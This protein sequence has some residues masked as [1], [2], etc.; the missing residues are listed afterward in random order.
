L[1]DS[2]IFNK[3]EL[4]LLYSKKPEFRPIK[5]LTLNDAKKIR[6]PS[7]NEADVLTQPSIDQIIVEFLKQ[8]EVNIKPQNVGDWNGWDTIA[9]IDAFMNRG[10]GG[11]TIANTLFY[12]SRSNQVSQSAQDWQTWKRWALDHKNFDKYK[13]EVIQNIISHN[14]NAIKE[15]EALIRKAELHNKNAIKEVEESIRKAELHNEKLVKKLQKLELKEYVSQLVESDN[16]RKKQIRKIISIFVLLIVLIGS[17]RFIRSVKT[18]KYIEFGLENGKKENYKEAISDFKN[19]INLNSNSSTAYTAYYNLGIIYNNLE[20]FE[21]ALLNLNKGLDL[22][23]KY[24]ED[25]DYAYSERAYVKYK[26]GDAQ[27]ALIDIDKA[28]SI[29]PTFNMGEYYFER[30]VYRK[31]LGNIRG[32]CDDITTLKFSFGKIPPKAIQTWFEES[33]N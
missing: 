10:S 33:C 1:K 19:A 5:V 16:L 23:S 3:R 27:G 30:F 28:I 8:Y 2:D 9:T 13:D 18:R 6:V 7:I 29:R 24:H 12:A 26:L 22:P 21:D 11:S 4:R 14:E 31:E 15:V 25:A 17:F 32:A 20:R